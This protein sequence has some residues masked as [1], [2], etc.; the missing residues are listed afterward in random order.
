MEILKFVVDHG[1]MC[2]ILMIGA[3]VAAA[4][5]IQALRGKGT[6]SEESGDGD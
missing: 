5:V 6:S 1:C 4:M 3:G 2:V